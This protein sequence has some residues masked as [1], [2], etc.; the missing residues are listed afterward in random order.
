MSRV[1]CE[2]EVQNGC[3][4][5]DGFYARFE[6]RQQEYDAL[7]ARLGWVPEVREAHEAKVK[8]ET[9]K[10]IEARKE[11]DAWLARIEKKKAIQAKANSKWAKAKRKKVKEEKEAAKQL[12]VSSEEKK[13]FI[14]EEASMRRE[15]KLQPTAGKLQFTEVT[16]KTLATE[17]VAESGLPVGI[18]RVFVFEQQWTD[19]ELWASYVE[20][21]DEPFPDE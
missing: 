13:W 4:R 7:Q 17:I 8:A 20:S 2:N 19:D 18:G 14:Q 21:M 3:P 1:Y 10:K 9:Q 11:S 6:A 5:V 12:P 15:G 16:D